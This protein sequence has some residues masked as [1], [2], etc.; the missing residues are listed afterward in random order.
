M[1]VFYLRMENYVQKVYTSWQLSIPLLL[2]SHKGRLG[3]SARYWSSERCRIPEKVFHFPPDLGHSLSFPDIMYSYPPK[4]GSTVW[5]SD[6]PYE[7]SI[8]WYVWKYFA[9]CEAQEVCYFQGPSIL[10]ITLDREP[11]ALW[12]WLQGTHRRTDGCS[13]WLHLPNVCPQVGNQEKIFELKIQSDVFFMTEGYD[14][15]LDYYILK[16]RKLI[17]AL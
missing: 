9:Y 16:T 3:F 14:C 7:D 12:F 11:V 5:S 10:K 4:M 6:S 15:I 8:R 1:K 2:A 13:H 17:G